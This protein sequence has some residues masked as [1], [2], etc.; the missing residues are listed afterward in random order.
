MGSLQSSS[1]TEDFPDDGSSN[2]LYTNV[3]NRILKGEI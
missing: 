3:N 1:Y 2:E